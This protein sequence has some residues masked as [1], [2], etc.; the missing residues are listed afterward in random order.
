MRSKFQRLDM[1]PAQL[2]NVGGDDPAPL[3]DDL[4]REKRQAED[5]RCGKD[6]ASPPSASIMRTMRIGFEIAPLVAANLVL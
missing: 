2:G 5:E 6:H 3:G 1:P 4:R